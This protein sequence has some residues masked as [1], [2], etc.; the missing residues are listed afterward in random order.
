MEDLDSGS[1]D[2]LSESL[3][4]SRDLAVLE[5]SA[6]ETPT[7]EFRLRCEEAGQAVWELARLRLERE[8]AGFSPL[9]VGAYLRD[10]ARDDTPP[11]GGVWPE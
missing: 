9:S 8:R 5:G 6:A 1:M 7:A 11:E 4:L 3:A 10:L 2:W